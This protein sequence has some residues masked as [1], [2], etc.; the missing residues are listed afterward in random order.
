MDEEM[1]T[2]LQAFKEQQEREKQSGEV[3]FNKEKVKLEAA[4]AS[5]SHSDAMIR[6][7]SRVKIDSQLTK[8]EYDLQRVLASTA[9]SLASI[10]A[11][12]KRN[13]SSIKA[14]SEY[15]KQIIMSE[16][17]VEHTRNESEL[18]KVLA[19]AEG[20]VAGCIQK[21]N[22]HSLDLRRINNIEVLSQNEDLIISASGDDEAFVSLL[23]GKNSSPTS[24]LAEMSMLKN[25]FYSP[26]MQ[27]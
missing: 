4:M 11:D 19:S 23:E 17:Q 7:E 26:K 8:N 9:F 20:K 18:Q 25:A 21:K 27:R 10:E 5:G 22:K 1:Q 13:A 2:T 6:E 16:S 3:E 12:A 24:V 14:E 15:Q